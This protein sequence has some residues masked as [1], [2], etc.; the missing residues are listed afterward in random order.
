M[1]Q[2]SP[3]ERLASLEQN[4]ASMKEGFD[5]VE[6]A[7]G[8]LTD[9]VSNLGDKLDTRYPSKESVEL[10]FSEIWNEISNIKGEKQ[11]TKLTKPH[12]AMVWVTAGA[13]FISV[14]SLA[15]SLHL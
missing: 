11:R 4:F 6:K 12:W 14:L 13:V 3:E 8:K 2:T 10:R 9:T 7:V 5:R 15:I 1:G